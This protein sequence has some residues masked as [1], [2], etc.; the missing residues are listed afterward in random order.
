MHRSGWWL[1]GAACACYL[2]VG[3]P[4]WSVP[5]S[6]L[7]LPS[8]VLG[9]GLLA[10]G[11][12]SAVLLGLGMAHPARVLRVIGCT[13]PAVVLGRVVVETVADPTSHNLWPLEAA[14]AAVLGAGAA[15][16]GVAAGALLG[17]MR[18]SAGS[19]PSRGRR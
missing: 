11:L 5:Y 12:A 6:R 4:Y 7:S 9:P 19:L 16:P 1:A 2:M 8:A 15:L 13:V 17:R 14:I 10:V 3:V 18:E